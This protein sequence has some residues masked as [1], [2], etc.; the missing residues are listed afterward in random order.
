MT[1]ER[2]RTLGQ[3]GRQH[4]LG[5]KLPGGLQMQ[6][7]PLTCTF[8]AAPGYPSLDSQGHISMSVWLPSPALQAPGKGQAAK[9][10]QDQGGKTAALG[11][12]DWG[13][14]PSCSHLNSM[15]SSSP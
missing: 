12:E 5:W 2:G 10:E 6:L 14:A 13:L 8:I 1:A 3:S 11:A 4:F 15:K 7:L 9:G